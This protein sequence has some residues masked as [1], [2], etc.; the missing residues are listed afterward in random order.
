MIPIDILIIVDLVSRITLASI[1]IIAGLAKVTSNKSTTETVRG[2]GISSI[3]ISTVL[4]FSLPFVEIMIG[5]GLLLPGVGLVAGIASSFLFLCFSFVLIV[6]LIQGKSVSCGCFGKSRAEGVDHLTA[7][8][9]LLF[10]AASI[11]LVVISIL[12]SA[13]SSLQISRAA[14][15]LLSTIGL[16]FAL[17]GSV[18]SFW[19]HSRSVF[20][21]VA[22]SG[23][24]SSTAFEGTLLTFSRRHFLKLLAG[25]AA[26]FALP[27][28]KSAL[29]LCCRCQ[30]YRHYDPGCCTGNFFH[31]RHYFKRC[32]NSCTGQVGGWHSYQPDGCECECA[33]PVNTCGDTIYACTGSACYMNECGCAA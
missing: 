19:G 2:F 20:I 22:T 31:V 11:L 28:A 21:T 33:E 24:S 13:S 7:L 18:L 27:P 30:E 29:A 12:T 3:R 25:I 16:T 32:C 4:G 1:F 5:I 9:S 8:R 6:A 15:V 26:A 23:N 17:T 10:L 14:L